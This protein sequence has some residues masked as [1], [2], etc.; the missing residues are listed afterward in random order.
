MSGAE[1]LGRL[2]EALRHRVADPRGGVCARSRQDPDDDA[3]DV[4]ADLLPWVL[5]GQPELALED[6]PEAASRQ[7][8]RFG[9]DHRT[10]DLGEGE[11][12]YEHRDGLDASEKIGEPKREA[13]R[14]GGV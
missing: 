11:D 9:R 3:D 1:L 13:R 2:R 10:H 5:A 14:P 6:A 4:A 7:L 12:A 8:R